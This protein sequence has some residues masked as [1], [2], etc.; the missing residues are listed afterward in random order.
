MESLVKIGNLGLRDRLL[1]GFTC[2]AIPIVLVTFL[3]LYKINQMEYYSKHIASV[4]LPTKML[5]L[6]LDSEILQ[7]QGYV[8]EWLL[9]GDEDAKKQVY[10][11][12]A[13][14]KQNQKKNPKII[15]RDLRID[16][17]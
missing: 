9:T 3:F 8:Y 5:L 4:S 2:L 17:T 16:K 11:I 15:T 1:L 10:T 6:E 13:A 12:W 14:I 7:T